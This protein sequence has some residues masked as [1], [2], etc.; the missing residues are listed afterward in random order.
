MSIETTGPRSTAAAQLPK[1]SPRGLIVLPGHESAFQQLE[2][3]LR[4]E[5]RPVGTLQEVFFLRI[6]ECSWNLHRCRV[7]EAQLNLETDPLLDDATAAKSERIQ[8]YARANETS[9]TKALRELG[10]IQT[11]IQYRHEAFPLTQKQAEDPEQFERTPHSLSAVCDFKKVMTIVH[12]ERKTE[13][14]RVRKDINTEIAALG[15]ET[16]ALVQKAK[17]AA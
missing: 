3:G 11:E 2:A 1:P 13:A 10:R 14:D 8:K 9:L 7:A 5:L 17:A 12:H 4:S 16:R 6:L 15:A